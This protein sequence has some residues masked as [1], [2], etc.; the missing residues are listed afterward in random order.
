MIKAVKQWHVLSELDW[1]VSDS[2]NVW[3]YIEFTVG[4]VAASL[5]TLKPIFNWFL[6]TARTFTTGGRSRGGSY[7]AGSKSRG[8]QNKTEQW[9][10]NIAMNSYPSKGAE[11]SST[12]S[13]SPYHVSITGVA[14][15]EGWEAHRKE[16][17]ESIMPL[18]QTR[19]TRNPTGIMMTREITV[20]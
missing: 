4:I 1:T 8:Y 5:P 7:K 12:S 6:E 11:S 19:H 10:K 15:K 2:F 17:D 18:Q 13:Q 20:V 9:S 16:S 3:N 14:D